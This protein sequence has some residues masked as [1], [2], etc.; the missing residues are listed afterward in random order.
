M[1]SPKKRKPVTPPGKSKPAPSAGRSGSSAGRASVSGASE[2]VTELHEA[3]TSELETLADELSFSRHLEAMS[4]LDGGI[5]Q[6]KL[7]VEQIRMRGYRFKNFLER[8]VETLEQKWRAAR[9]ALRRELSR[10][11]AELTPLYDQL[12]RRVSQA[13]GRAQL[14]ALERQ[15]QQ[16]KAR[17]EAAT[18]AIDATYSNVSQTFY[19]TRSQIQEVL[20]LLEQVE[21]ASFDLLAGEHPVQAVRAKWW[22]DG[23]NKGPEGIL[24]LTDQRL[25]FEQKEEVATKKVLFVAT[26][27]ELRQE[28]LLE[29]PVGAVEAAR[30]IDKGLMGHQDHLEFTFG[31]DAP[32]ASAYFHIKGQD[33]HAWVGLVNR[34]R[35]GEINRER[36]YAEGES[37]EDFEQALEEAFASAPERCTSC[38]APLGPLTAGQR[39]IECEYCGTVM[40]W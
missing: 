15:V 30:A 31:E 34:V 25:I 36:Y 33:N 3:L 23:K 18:E 27:K 7:D 26:E 6:L 12:A 10:A 1:P 39:Q 16:L 22:R 2:E 32:Y 38:G 37:P 17:V 8:K 20:F 21:Q 9:P 28:M 4:D 19:Q 24:Y 35:T 29:V 13:S 11:E 40:R 14:S 5:S